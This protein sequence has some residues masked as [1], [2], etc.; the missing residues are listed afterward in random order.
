MINKFVM[1]SG[2]AGKIKEFNLLLNKSGYV[3]VSQDMYQITSIE[4]TGTTF[5]ENAILKARNACDQT[6]K[7]SI[8]DDSGLEVFALNGAPGLHSARFA[9]PDCDDNKNIMKLLEQMSEIP[10]QDRGAQFRCTVV[11]L[12]SADDPEPLISEGLWKGTICDKPRGNKGFGY[13]PIFWVTEE[14]CTAAELD[15]DHKNRISHRGKAMRDML[16]QIEEHFN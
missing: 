4:E 11:C 6:G 14:N 2:N 1:A 13:D 15:S 16:K 5:L 8:A 10:S 12:R 7:P 3:V 9:G